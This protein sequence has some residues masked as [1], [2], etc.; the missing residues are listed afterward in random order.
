[1]LPIVELDTIQIA[2]GAIQR[3]VRLEPQSSRLTLRIRH[4]YLQFT[5]AVVP[6]VLGR[7]YCTIPGLS[8]LHGRPIYHTSGLITIP[9][10]ADLPGNAGGELSIEN[11][12]GAAIFVT[13]GLDGYYIENES[14]EEEL[15]PTLRSS[16][17]V[18]SG[19]TVSVGAV[20]V[21]ML[22]FRVPNYRGGL[23]VTGVGVIN[24]LMTRSVI[25][26]EGIPGWRPIRILVARLFP[27]AAWLPPLR[28][29]RILMRR[30]T[31][32]PTNTACV[33]MGHGLE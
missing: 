2:A 23:V 16:S 1:L 22:R 20:D 29:V 19:A 4:L 7:L 9:L 32:A 30:E 25:S 5:G 26:F 18:A 24:F 13:A 33:V 28:D 6:T 17:F 12:T 14:E 3:F 21:E 10:F 27:F 15:R 11:Q 8:D 31:G